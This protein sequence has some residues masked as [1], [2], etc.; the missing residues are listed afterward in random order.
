ME[1]F[2][3]ILHDKNAQ[4]RKKLKELYSE[5]LYTTNSVLPLTICYICFFHTSTI[6][7]LL[8]PYIGPFFFQKKLQT[9]VHFIPK[10][11][12]IHIIN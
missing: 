4:Q 7:P 1:E 3:F 2:F 6:Y 5:Y 9:A 11:F 10:Y 12:I 8:Y